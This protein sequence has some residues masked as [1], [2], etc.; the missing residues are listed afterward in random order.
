MWRQHL[1]YTEGAA[2]QHADTQRTQRSGRQRSLLTLISGLFADTQRTQR[3][4]RQRNGGEECIKARRQWLAEK[5]E[6]V[7]VAA[8]TWI[9]CKYSNWKLEADQMKTDRIWLCQS[10]T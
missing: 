6:V 9:G 3:S 8:A 1:S 7:G 2:A 4:G 5:E 10:I